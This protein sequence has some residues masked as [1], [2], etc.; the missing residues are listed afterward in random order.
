MRF[1]GASGNIALWFFQGYPVFWSGQAPM[2]QALSRVGLV[3][4]LIAA[5]IGAGPAWAKTPE[6]LPQVSVSSLPAEAQQTVRLIHNGGPFPYPKDGIV[7]GN[8]ERLLPGKARGY[9]REY[10]VPTPGSHD[11]GARRVVCGGT[12]PRNPDTCYYT[13][14]H[15]ASFRRIAQ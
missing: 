12:Q 14:D 7:F 10:T 2:R 6:P 13:A 9:Y 11:R 5:T 15:Y 1:W 3:G 4:V 8:N